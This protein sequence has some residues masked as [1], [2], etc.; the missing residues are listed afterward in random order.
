MSSLFNKPKPSG[1]WHHAAIVSLICL[2]LVLPALIIWGSVVSAMSGKLLGKTD[3]EYKT[4]DGAVKDGVLW[5]SVCRQRGTWLNQESFDWRIKRLDLTTCEE[6]E[7]GLII[8][9]GESLYTFRINDEI[10]AA[11]DTTLY[12]INGSSLEKIVS[13]PKCSAGPFAQPFSYESQLTAIAD[14]DDR[15]FRLVHLANDHWVDGRRI[16][17]PGPGRSWY[18]DLQRNRKSLLALTSAEQPPTFVRS[19]YAL[20][21]PS[22]Y[23]RVVS[24]GPD[25]HI[26][27]T[28]LRKYAAYR[29]GFEFADEITDEASA[30]APEN[31]LREV[32]GWE[33][34]DPENAPA[35]LIYSMAC[36]RQGLLCSDYRVHPS[37]FRRINNGHWKTIDGLR[38]QKIFRANILADPAEKETYLVQT[39]DRWISATV[40]RLVDN[41]V[42]PAHLT[43]E[44]HVPSYLA[45]W[46]RLI[47]GIFVAWL[48]HHLVLAC[49]LS[50]CRYKTQSRVDQFGIQDAALASVWQRLIALV[51]DLLCGAVLFMVFIYFVLPN[52]IN[53]DQPMTAKDICEFLF[54]YER[55]L[56][57]KVFR[58]SLFT[59]QTTLDCFQYIVQEL[60]GRREYILVGILLVLVLWFVK[61]G[62]ERLCGFTPGKW[63]MGIRTVRS[64]L[65]P[66]GVPQLLVRDLLF[67]LDIPF[68]VTSF[69]AA[70]SMFWSLNGQ[71]VGDRVADT[72][73][74]QS[75]TATATLAY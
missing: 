72:I 26:C 58:G 16:L 45:Q 49:G 17:F 21:A 52:S 9:D 73:V 14:T 70:I 18:D 54:Q 66:A 35:S 69:P 67:C 10:Y 60:Q 25:I 3:S 50:W 41:T 62:C 30:L 39:N 44:G 61:V 7:T 74:I 20:A 59:T 71:R 46:K 40:H 53:G 43:I 64:T 48:T 2:S 55:A 12:R 51:A 22:I 38:E 63:L 24:H 75:L 37:V 4:Y 6:Q 23:V 29:N 36:D 42:Q 28:D 31:S 33:P 34:I 47:L 15:G 57:L 5:I 27:V 8:V 56:H 19:P 1:L 68:L 32:T 13:M 65:R 11:T